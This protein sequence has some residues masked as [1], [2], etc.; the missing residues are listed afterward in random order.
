MKSDTQ[1]QQDV[2]SE[3]IW[4]PSVNAAD[5]GV[6]V[7]DGIVTLVGHVA[8]YSEKIA[9]ECAAQ[10]VAGIRGLAIEIDV[11]LP[12]SS[13]RNDVDIARAA[14]NVLSWSTFVATDSIKVMVEQGWITLRGEVRWDFERRSAE[15]AVRHLMGVT[16]VSD[17]ILIK[18]KVSATVLK[19]DIDEVIKRR[20][21]EDAKNI[22][23]EVKGAD[24]TLSGTVHTWAERDLAGHAA[25]STPGVS[26]VFNNIAITY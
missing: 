5:I 8:S 19:A 12:G 4:E 22:S 2:N 7:K 17:Q 9:A 10:R 3:L 6:Q 13:K 14:E 20:A 23:V 1:L 25:W 24:V 15:D 26:T 11:E 21:R 16:G 18:E